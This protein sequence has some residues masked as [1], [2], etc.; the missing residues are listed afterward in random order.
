LRG[1]CRVFLIVFERE[2]SCLP[3]RARQALCHR[4]AQ[5][6]VVI[7]R[8]ARERVG[9]CTSKLGPPVDGTDAAD[10]L[11]R[12][13]RPP[14]V[15]PH[16]GLATTTTTVPTLSRRFEG[17][18]AAVELLGPGPC[19]RPER[20]AEISFVGWPG[21][22][23]KPTSN[24][25]T[26]QPVVLIAKRWVVFHAR[27]KSP[28]STSFN[29]DRRLPEI[30]PRKLMDAPPHAYPER[31]PRTTRDGPQRIAVDELVGCEDRP[32]GRLSRIVCSVILGGAQPDPLAP[33]ATGHQNQ[34]VASL[35][36]PVL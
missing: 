6:C 29:R 13:S 36:V 33:C 2:R 30:F 12:R 9:Q 5:H 11:P 1:R 22:S 3:R 20:L 25:P 23:R 32:V 19:P 8:I 15:I 10:R 16:A 7:Q 17:P 34:A 18:K 35:L 31:S 14:P 21:T 28:W 24:R 27:L 26:P 4:T